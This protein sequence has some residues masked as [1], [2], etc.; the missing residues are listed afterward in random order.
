MLRWFGRPRPARGRR[1]S[2][3]TAR[4]LRSSPGPWRIRVLLGS[5]SA[6]VPGHDM[7]GNRAFPVS[8]AFRVAIG[9]DALNS[10]YGDPGHVHDRADL[11]LALRNAVLPPE[12]ARASDHRG[13][14]S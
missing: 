12:L 8:P 13:E 2:A 10:V 9:P 1:S 14:R 11:R 6:V 5:R 4:A 3:R 7:P